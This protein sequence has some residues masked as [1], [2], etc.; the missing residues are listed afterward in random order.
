MF[1]SAAFDSRAGGV[2]AVEVKEEGDVKEGRRGSGS[3]RGSGAAYG[4][5]QSAAHLIQNQDNEY[6]T[7]HGPGHFACLFVEI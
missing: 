4:L 3:R 1:S 6:A 7:L 2:V 5:E